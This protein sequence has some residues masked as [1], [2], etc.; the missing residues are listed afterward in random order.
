MGKSVKL[1]TASFR[2]TP[3]IE[4]CLEDALKA[5]AAKTEKLVKEQQTLK[6]TSMR[7]CVNGLYKCLKSF[8]KH[9]G[10]TSAFAMIRDLSWYWSSFCTT[11]ET[12]VNLVREYY[13]LLKDLTENTD[14][15]DLWDRMDEPLPVKEVGWRG[16][17]FNVSVPQV[18]WGAIQDCAMAL[19]TS[20]STF[21]QVGLS[22]AMASD[23]KGRYVAW[24]ATVFVPLFDEFMQR[25]K[26][27]LKSLQ[28]IRHLMG[29]RM[30]KN[31]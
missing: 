9:Y 25:S 31:D 23:S 15:T 29:Y 28:E 1:S 26:V 16:H 22:K 11:D 5:G 27:R 8:A 18:A 12:M 21:Y 10:E 30:A 3:I 6:E 2:D 24:A 14:F 13:S 17:P 19:G 4:L 7:F 20:S